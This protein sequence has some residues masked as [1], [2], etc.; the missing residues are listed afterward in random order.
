MGRRESEDTGGKEKKI[1]SVNAS[2]QAS[3]KPEGIQNFDEV[4]SVV[5]GVLF[6]GMSFKSALVWYAAGKICREVIA[7][8]IYAIPRNLT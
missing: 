1:W 5:R 8:K 3:M 7:G 6:G 4:L 2:K